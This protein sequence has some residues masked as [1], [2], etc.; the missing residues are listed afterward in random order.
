MTMSSFLLDLLETILII[1]SYEF[2]RWLVR[3]FEKEK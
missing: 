2:G 1:A 3:C